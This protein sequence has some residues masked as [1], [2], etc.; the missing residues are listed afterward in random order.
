MET[1]FQR[2]RADNFY[3]LYTMTL[4]QLSQYDIFTLANSGSHS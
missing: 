2:L 4:R 1:L 3:I